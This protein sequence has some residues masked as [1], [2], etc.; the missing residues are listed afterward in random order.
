LVA[1]LLKFPI[2]K[3]DDQVDVL[4]LLGRILNR[5]TSGPRPA[6]EKERM[7]GINDIT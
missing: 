2:G 1:E 3:Y 6:P 4:S 7:L 5:M